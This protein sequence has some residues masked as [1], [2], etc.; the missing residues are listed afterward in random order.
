M[1]NHPNRGWRSRWSIDLESATATHRDGWVFKF[2]PVDGEPGAF[3]GECVVMPAPPSPLT[4]EHLAQ[5]SRIAREAGDIY[6][7]ARNDRH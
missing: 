1:V 5:A 7:E 3:D 6:I 2:S 4:Q